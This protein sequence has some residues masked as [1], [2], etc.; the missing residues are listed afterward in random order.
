MSPGCSWQQ[1]WR[2]LPNGNAA[3]ITS[4][5]SVCMGGP[6]KK[7]RGSVAIFTSLLPRPTIKHAN[8]QVRNPMMRLACQQKDFAGDFCPIQNSKDNAAYFIGA[9]HAFNI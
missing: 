9:N 4:P 2:T 6:A 1:G 8:R 5:P 3:L 7:R